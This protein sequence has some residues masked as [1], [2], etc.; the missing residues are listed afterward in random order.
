MKLH[1]AA[2]LALVGLYLMAPPTGPDGKLAGPLPQ[3][4]LLD[5]FDSATHYEA[6]KGNF[7]KKLQSQGKSSE[8]LMCP[9]GANA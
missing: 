7:L 8:T 5:S 6:L 1:H 2:A 3:W 4:I 9:W